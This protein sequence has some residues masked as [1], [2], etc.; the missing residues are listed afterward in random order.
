MDIKQQAKLELA[1]RELEKRHAEQRESLYSF[2]L[3]F[4]EQE[5]KISLD[6]NWH[7]KAIC[8]KL[9]AVYR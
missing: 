4:W 2:L 9:E 1:M 6:E 3:Y 5:K 7:L 8:D